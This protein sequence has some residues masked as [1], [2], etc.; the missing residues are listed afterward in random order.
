MDGRTKVRPVEGILALGGPAVI[1]AVIGIVTILGDLVESGL[2]RSAGVKDSGNL[3]PGRGGMLD[4]ID[5]WLFSA[6][7]LYYLL[8]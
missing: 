5:S 4:S 8:R 6:V 3:I 1:G 2:K 7:A